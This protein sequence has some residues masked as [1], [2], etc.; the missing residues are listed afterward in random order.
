MKTD[1]HKRLLPVIRF[2][3]T[4]FDQPFNLEEVARMAYLSPYHFHRIFKAVV[5]ETLND[6][7]RRLRME[8]A[9]NHLFYKKLSVVDVALSM[10][11]S[12]SQAFAKAF[13]QHFGLTASQVANA[14][15]W[16]RLLCCYKTA[17]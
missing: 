10:G 13:K 2:L 14:I 7:L 17:R 16:R 9:A 12:S 15:I 8:K 11:F 5:G 1:Y 3:E 4:N 6:Y